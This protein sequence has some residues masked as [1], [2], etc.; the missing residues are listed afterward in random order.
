MLRHGFW[1]A[2]LCLVG[3]SLSP[4]SFAAP[5]KGSAAANLEWHD[6]S[7]ESL[8]R[9]KR[10]KR[11]VLL[12]L[13][14]VWCHWCHV[15][16]AETYSNPK[17]QKVLREHYFLIRVDQDSRPDL[18]NRY[19]DYGWP[20]TIIF[21]YDGRELAKRSGYIEPE[22]MESLLTAIVKDPTPGPSVQADAKLEFPKTALMSEEVR[23]HLA[24][25]Y[26][27]RY[28]RKAGSWGIGSHKFLDWNSTEYALR[29][30]KDGDA[31]NT[32]MAK[33]TLK[34]QLNLL[35]PVWGGVYQYSTG[36][37]W[38]NRTLKRSCSFRRGICASTPWP[39]RCGATPS[40][41]R[42]PSVLPAIYRASCAILVAARSM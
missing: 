17:V 36:G 24:T 16:D 7:A 26:L 18:A 13:E 20:A 22:A 27:E 33:Q 40:I 30:A 42:P 21:H 12:D 2:S 9:A 14:A 25:R 39:M 23:A 15:M 41:C 4:S 38:T 31:E 10:E 37:V 35:D 32:A 3:L 6:W 29:R 28:D 11:H 34:A 5:A 8:A 19:E 1:I